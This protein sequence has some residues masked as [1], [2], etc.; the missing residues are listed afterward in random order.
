MLYPSGMSE[1]ILSFV[2]NA[3]S[4]QE[5]NENLVTL[6]HSC[7]LSTMHKLLVWLA[8][9]QIKAKTDQAYSWNIT[10]M[11]LFFQTFGLAGKFVTVIYSVPMTCGSNAIVYGDF[12]HRK[13]GEEIY[14][15]L[16]QIFPLTI[17]ECMLAC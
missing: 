12:Y 4:S 9:T 3:S 7:L 15:F 8:A 14:I 13:E 17:S 1:F 10:N 2:I 6:K 16:M 5:L 11:T